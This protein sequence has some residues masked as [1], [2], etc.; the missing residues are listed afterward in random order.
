MIIINIAT[1]SS[2][3]CRSCLLYRC[4]RRIR[5]LVLYIVGLSIVVFFEATVALVAIIALSSSPLLLFLLL[6]LLSFLVLLSWFFSLLPLHSVFI[7]FLYLLSTAP[8]APPQGL[9]VDRR[10]QSAPSCD[11]HDHVIVAVV[12]AVEVDFVAVSAAAAVA[13]FHPAFDPNPIVHDFA[14][15][16]TSSAVPL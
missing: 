6:L 8:S 1:I 12:D 2:S 11:L 14:P 16:V 9:V 15:A 3:S 13:A 5:S 10:P 4:C 7:F